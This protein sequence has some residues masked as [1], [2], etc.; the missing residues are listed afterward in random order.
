MTLLD[1]TKKLSNWYNVSFEIE[2]SLRNKKIYGQIN[3]TKSIRQ[4]LLLISEALDIKFEIRNNRVRI[5][6]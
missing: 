6:K 3:R 2:T 1:A 4:I 5:F